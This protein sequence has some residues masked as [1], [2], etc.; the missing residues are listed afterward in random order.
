MNRLR[1]ALFPTLLHALVALGASSAL[2]QPGALVQLDGTDGCISKDGSGGECAQGSGLAGALD[3]AVSPDGASV[4]VASFSSDAVA[5]LRR[6]ESKAAGP[7]G[8]LTQD[9]T[10]GCVSESGAAPCVGGRGLHNPFAVVVSPDGKSVY[11][12]GAESDAVAVFAR[13]S[14]TSLL[15]QLA[16]SDGCAT[17]DGA[18]DGCSAASGLGRPVGL[19]MPRDG[20]FLYVTANETASLAALPRTKRGIAPVGA[21]AAGACWSESAAECIAQEGLGG[22]LGIAISRDGRHL[23]VASQGAGGVLAFKRNARTGAVTPL[24]G[25]DACITA[26]GSGGRCTQGRGLNG[27][28]TL[29]LSHDGRHLYVASEFG[30]AVAV[31]AR[32]RKTGRLTQLPDLDGCVVEGGSLTC[33]AGRALLS[34][35]GIAVSRDGR[36]V[37]VGSAGSDAVAVFARDR[38]TGRLTQLPGAAGC[39]SETGSN[40]AC[41]DGKA[42][43]N[44]GAVAVSADGKSVYVASFTSGAVATFA[45]QLR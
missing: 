42:L 6:N 38:K 34:P 3:L 35:R 2:A 37:Y 7:I 11:V 31:L 14:Q 20:K 44:P 13:D 30:N 15:Q 33:A 36:N 26:N 32:D 28:R 10:G 41:T 23:Y 22:G 16:G 17:E 29:A 4:Y 43:R 8:K 40:G 45:R 18:T 12:A 25:L 9:A 19:G 21:L 39:V 5:M 27:A 1:L 24:P